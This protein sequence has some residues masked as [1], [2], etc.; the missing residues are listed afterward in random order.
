M[1]TVAIEKKDI[2][3]LV[4]AVAKGGKFFGPVR[5]DDKVRLVEVAPGD[6][7]SLDYGNFPLSLKNLFFPRAQVVSTCAD[8]DLSAVE[9][10][11][12][13]AVIFGARP[14][15]IAALLCLDKVFMAEQYVDPY[16]RSRREHSVIIAFACAEPADVC[17]C[18]SVG[19]GPA[20]T[21][22]ADVLATDAGDT[23]LF[24]AVSDNGMGFMK[25]HSALF[26][27][28]KPAETK[29]AE[30]RCRA[31]E[32]KIKTL[33]VSVATA[34]AKLA[35]IFDSPLW[36]EIA[37]RC[38]GCGVCTFTCPTCHC[39]ALSDER[40][41]RV[42]AHDA[43]MFES[44]TLEASGHNPRPKKGDR[45]RQRVMHKF[46]YAVENFEEVFCVGC[47]RCVAQCP[48]NIDIR[49]TLSRISE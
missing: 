17:F 5:H 29:T 2:K 34:T 24:T 42:R 36:D 25:K 40:R 44:F 1:K 37:E 13:D 35:E 3:K 28:P 43:C 9:L 33:A 30:A 11:E 27:E 8:K 16:Y 21:K 18:V 41:Q 26:R 31:A 4:A 32:K 15:D 39:F 19:G 14:C 23:V 22:G 7:L 6:E 10:D 45:L 47:G 38:L 49:E 46:R 48:V 20:D 12:T